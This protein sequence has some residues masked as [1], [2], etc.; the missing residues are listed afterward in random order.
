MDVAFKTNPNKVVCWGRK[1]KIWKAQ[2]LADRERK[3]DMLH[4]F[5]KA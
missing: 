5:G 1:G 2:G 3:S 4:D